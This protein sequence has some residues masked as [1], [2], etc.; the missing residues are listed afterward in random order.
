MT[1]DKFRSNLSTILSISE[2]GIYSVLNDADF[3]E[4]ICQEVFLV[5]L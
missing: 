5:I 3:S 2:K 4:D 1:E